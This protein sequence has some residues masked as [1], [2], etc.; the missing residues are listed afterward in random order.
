[1]DDWSASDRA[2]AAVSGPAP[3]H[4]RPVTS[5]LTR[6]RPFMDDFHLFEDA[7]LVKPPF[8]GGV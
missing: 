6:A 8:G 4:P 7:W 2:P 3:N 1:M 5:A